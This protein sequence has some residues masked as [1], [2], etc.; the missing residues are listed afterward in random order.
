MTSSPAAEATLTINLEAIASNYR[1]LAAKCPKAQCAAVVKADSYGTGM[2]QV[3]PA[4]E[5]ADCQTFFVATLKEGLQLRPLLQDQSD[6]YIFN[7]LPIGRAA[8]LAS[9]GLRPVLGDMAEVREWAGFCRQHNSPFPAALHFDTGMNRLGLVPAEFADPANDDLF[10]DF[11]PA[12]VMSHLACGDTPD[13]PMNRAQLHHFR[14]LR[15]VFPGATACLANSAGI[16]L[17]EDYHF[18]MV[19]PGIALYGGC[20]VEN[21][22]NPMAQVAFLQAQVLKVK[23]VPKGQPVGYGGNTLMA[24]DSI[25]ATLDVGYADGYHR[26]L[27]A[28]LGHQGASV[29]FQGQKCPLLGR[30]SMDL[31]TVDI[32]DASPAPK[33]GDLVEIIGSTI[34]IDALASQANTISYEILTSLGRRYARNYQPAKDTS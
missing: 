2:A 30:V 24:R 20:P 31:L 3:A 34:T 21:T 11:S 13:H 15:Q 26:Q 4:L 25:V 33:R 1:L 22:E 7:G 28:G 16:F 29:A 14:Q 10:T 5:R 23:T 9:N 6:I 17:G 18:D 12:L 32:T 8:L 19:R 27:G